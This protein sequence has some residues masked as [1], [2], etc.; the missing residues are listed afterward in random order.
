M[1]DLAQKELLPPHGDTKPLEGI[2]LQAL[3]EQLGAEW[4]IVEDHHLEKTY[5][6]NNFQEALDFTNKIGELAESVDHHPEI[7]L[8]WGV[9]RITIWTHSIGGLSEADFVFAAKCDQLV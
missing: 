5:K 7:C 6:F 3:D 2:A 9:V 1:S 4:Q 8:T